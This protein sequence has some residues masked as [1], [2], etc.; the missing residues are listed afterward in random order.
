MDAGASCPDPFSVHVRSSESVLHY[1]APGSAVNPLPLQQR[2]LRMTTND[3]HILG[4][5]D[6][7]RV[8]P[9]EYEILQP[10]DPRNEKRN[11]LRAVRYEPG[12]QTHYFYTAQEYF[13]FATSVA[14]RNRLL[15]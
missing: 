5:F 9:P 10:T 14:P 1:T 4:L 8:I 6:V 15:T 13:T 7:D 3:T 11:A 2:S 12:A